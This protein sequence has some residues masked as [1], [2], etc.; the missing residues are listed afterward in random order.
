M[1]KLLW[2]SFWHSL[3]KLLLFSLLLPKCLWNEYS[4][5]TILDFYCPP[6]SLWYFSIDVFFSLS[7]CFYSH[8][9]DKWACQKPIPSCLLN[10][11][12]I[13]VSV[14]F[15]MCLLYPFIDICLLLRDYPHCLNNRYTYILVYQSGENNQKYLVICFSVS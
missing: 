4:H 6:S 1:G 3:V 10:Y 11:L 2:K 7:K 9:P 5:L 12:S 15:C 8:L 13:N 14:Y